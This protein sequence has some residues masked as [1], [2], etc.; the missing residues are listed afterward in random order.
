MRRRRLST[1]LLVVSLAV[2]ALLLPDAL[3]GDRSVHAQDEDTQNE[4]DRLVAAAQNAPEAEKVDRWRELAVYLDRA[5]AWLDGAYAWHQAWLRTQDG[6]DA[7]REAQHLMFFAEQ[8]LAAAESGAATKASFAD[9]EIALTRARDAG[10]SPDWV[11]I[12][13]ARC[14]AALGRTDDQVTLLQTTIREHPRS[15]AARRALAFA[16]YHAGRDKEAMAAFDGLSASGVARLLPLVLTRADAARRSGDD[17][18]A[19][20]SAE[21]A[22]HLAPNDS[23]GW[24]ALWKIFAADKRFGEL[25]KRMDVLAQAHPDS[26]SGAHYAGFAC[27]SA[28]DYDGALRWL[29]RAVELNENNVTPRL[30]IA[31]ILRDVKRDAAGA[32][33]Q[34]SLV[35][36]TVPSNAM[37]VSALN[38]MAG[39]IS[40][41]EGRPADAVPLF[42][43][44][45]KARPEDGTAWANLALALRWSGQN[46]PARAAY[47]RAEGFSPYDPQIRNDHGLLLLVMGLDAEA[48][49]RFEDAH[50][51]DERHNDGL[52]NLGFMDRELNDLAGAERWFHVAWGAARARGEDGGRHRRNLDDTRFPLPPLR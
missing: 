20:R 22:I 47:T 10:Q 8:V 3:L 42:E 1:W 14:A 15:E 24:R 46:E 49:S 37:A 32:I 16:L 2:P 23:R 18:E 11:G 50:S 40:D 7:L 21:R 44:I 48:R 9:A 29:Q 41:R 34:Y 19:R 5:G 25:A 4:R 31:R 28:A 39:Q 30:E 43:T 38:Y 51:V 27:A 17:A 35:L 13:L 26:G 45:V 33:A 6:T 52:E 12:G 36:A